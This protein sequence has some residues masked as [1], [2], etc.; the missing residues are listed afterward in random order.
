MAA[1]HAAIAGLPTGSLSLF[2]H[3]PN[4][5]APCCDHGQ[6]SETCNDDITDLDA[7]AGAGGACV[8][9]GSLLDGGPAC[10]RISY[11]APDPNMAGTL[12]VCCPM[13]AIAD[14]AAG[15]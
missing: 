14:A 5:G 12:G 8:P 7:C 10:A 9:Y 11:C 1:Y 6:C 4:Y 15:D 3:C 2:C 13:G